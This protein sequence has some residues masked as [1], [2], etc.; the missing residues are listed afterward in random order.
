MLLLQNAESDTLGFAVKSLNLLE[1]ISRLVFMM[2]CV[3]KQNQY[4]NLKKNYKIW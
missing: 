4:K 1:K 3:N 2:L